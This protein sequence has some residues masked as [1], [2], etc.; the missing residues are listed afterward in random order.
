MTTHVIDSA[1]G[2]RTTVLA[3]GH[4]KGH[5]LIVDGGS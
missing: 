2:W 1:D 4:N 3:P 5:L